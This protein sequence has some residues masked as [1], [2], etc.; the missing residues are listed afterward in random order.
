MSKF[1]VGDRVR[2]IRTQKYPQCLGMICAIKGG[3]KL[4]TD[5]STGKRLLRYQLDILAPGSPHHA[6][7]MPSQIE[8]Y[9]DGD[10]P[11]KWSECVWQPKQVTA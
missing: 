8:P 3:L 7:V 6:L 5:L 1:K 9:Y 10:E 11:A 4:R 2:I